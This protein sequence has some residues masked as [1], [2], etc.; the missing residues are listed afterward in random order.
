MFSK[1]NKRNTI[2]FFLIAILTITVLIAWSV[3]SISRYR[4]VYSQTAEVESHSFS[5]ELNEFSDYVNERLPDGVEL[6]AAVYD[7]QISPNGSTII[8]VNVDSFDKALSVM[9]TMEEY[10]NTSDSVLNND[11]YVVNMWSGH[12][13][14]S[15]FLVSS[16]S[17]DESGCYNSLIELTGPISFEHVTERYTLESVNTVR[18]DASAGVDENQITTME[19]LF[20]NAEIIWL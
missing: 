13:V 18:I 9:D 19:E 4:K 20:P 16:V 10:L 12:G 6:V 17:V 7:N 2:K 15:V 3:V 1:T 5:S 11:D 8:F 14:D